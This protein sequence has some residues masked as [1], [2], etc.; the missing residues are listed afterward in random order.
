[1]RIL[2]EGHDSYRDKE[3]R[4]YIHLVDGGI[5]DNLGVRSLLE[6]I[7]VTGGAL[8]ALKL[9][10]APLPKY[11]IVIVVNAETR[12]ENPMDSSNKSPSNSR[13][14]GA[15]SKAQ[16]GRYNLESL[17]L[18]EDALDRWAA[19]LSTSEHKVTP[20]FI[21]LDFES[22]ADERTRLIFN[23]MATSFSLPNEE[24]DD[25]IEAGHQLLRH[26]PDY[27]RLVALIRE[28]EQEQA[29]ST[30]AP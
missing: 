9:S 8:S 29:R 26:S 21:K 14:V 3:K 17:V 15:V 1:V 24:V 12:A 30:A 10:N 22:I 6:R 20:Y 11:I 25:L 4:R 18:L 13:V 16:I 5:T 19:E 2:V 7:E 27:Q 28:A 23:N